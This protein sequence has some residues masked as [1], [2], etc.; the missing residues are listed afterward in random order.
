MDLSATLQ[1][2]GS[3]LLTVAPALAG[4]ILS[5][6]P[7]TVMSAFSSIKSALGL[8]PTAQEAEVDAAITGT[9]E[10]RLK[11]TVAENEFKLAMRRADNDELFTRLADVQNARTMNIEG[12]KATGKRDTEDKVF[13]WIIVI[14]LFTIIGA[15][16]YLRPPESTILGGLIG[17]VSTAFIAVVQFRKGTTANSQAKTNIIANSTP[18]R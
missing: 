11:L 6:N 16:M 1:S 5:P 2:I 4:A 14:G 18:N 8:A 17:T 10:E 9:P 3:K 7:G 12:V 15:M 13:D